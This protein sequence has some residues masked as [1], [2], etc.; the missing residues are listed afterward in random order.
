[1]VI[2]T[3]NTKIPFCIYGTPE[4]GFS[5]SDCNGEIAEEITPNIY[6]GGREM[7][8]GYL[9]VI[10]GEQPENFDADTT[11]LT[12]PDGVYNFNFGA[13]YLGLLHIACDTPN[14]KVYSGNNNNHN[15]YNG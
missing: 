2:D 15:H 7:Y 10:R 14:D 5:L 1:M 12:L 4:E 11:Y 9:Y 13:D 3:P 8:V 6:N